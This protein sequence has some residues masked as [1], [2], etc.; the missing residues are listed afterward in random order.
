MRFLAFFDHAFPSTLPDGRFMALPW[1]RVGPA[2]AITTS[3]RAARLRIVMVLYIVLLAAVN[4]IPAL[5]AHFSATTVS[6]AAIVI[7]TPFFNFLC[8][9]GL[10]KIDKPPRRTPE[11]IRAV[12]LAHVRAVGRSELRLRQIVTGVLAIVFATWAVLVP[13][14]RAFGMLL[15]LVFA[16]V[17]VAN[18]EL[19]V[20]ARHADLTD[21]S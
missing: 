5:S 3:Q 8:T 16:P 11:Q 1:G 15:F 18:R 7:F 13:E 14:M 6:I 17:A 21:S 2:Y 10:Q 9:I 4:R 12:M 20:L 19:L